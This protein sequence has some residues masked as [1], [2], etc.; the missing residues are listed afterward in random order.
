MT[1]LL[2]GFYSADKCNK[3][4][5]FTVAL[6]FKHVQHLN[7]WSALLCT[8]SW[9]DTNAEVGKNV[10]LNKAYSIC[11]KPWVLL[12]LSKDPAVVKKTDS[13]SLSTSFYVMTLVIYLVATMTTV[14]QPRCRLQHVSQSSDSGILSNDTSSAPPGA[15]TAWESRRETH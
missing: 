11:E 15:C 3:I 1:S 13:H 7:S 4:N 5:S 8:L 14:G 10:F 12:C 2:H 9:K 6:L